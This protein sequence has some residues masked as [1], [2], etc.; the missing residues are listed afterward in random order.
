MLAGE[1]KLDILSIL[2]CNKNLGIWEFENIRILSFLC[3]EYERK[4]CQGKQNEI[5]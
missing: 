1:L 3:G 4:I 5:L 2:G